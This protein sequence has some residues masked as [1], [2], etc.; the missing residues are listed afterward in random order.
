MAEARFTVTVDGQEYH[1]VPETFVEGAVRRQ[2]EFAYLGEEDLKSRP[3]TRE[4]LHNSWIG[5]AQWE[6]PVYGRNNLNTYFESGDLSFTDRAGA[7]QQSAELQPLDSDL[8]TASAKLIAWTE[9]SVDGAITFA[10][11]GNAWQWH[12]WNGTTNAW[13]AQASRTTAHTETNVCMAATAGADGKAYALM[14]NGAISWYDPTANTN[15]NEAG[16]GS[17]VN[18]ASMW[19]DESYVWVYSGARI[20]RYDIAD[21]YAQELIANDGDGVDVFALSA[22]FTTKPIIPEWSCTRAITTS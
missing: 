2:A 20:H 8:D 12:K 11:I 7:V 14:L 3:D 10:W 9:D 1:I 22:D 15:G 17:V 18:G 6:K 19:A 5:G 21:S 16:G 13:D 4:F